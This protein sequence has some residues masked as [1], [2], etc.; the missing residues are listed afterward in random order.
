M[1]CWVKTSELHRFCSPVVCSMVKA[2]VQVQIHTNLVKF[3][4]YYQPLCCIIENDSLTLTLHIVDN[5]SLQAGMRF[6]SSSSLSLCFFVMTSPARG[7]EATKPASIWPGNWQRIS[8][9]ELAWEGGGFEVAGRT[10]LPKALKTFG[11]CFV[12][13]IHPAA[14]QTQGRCYKKAH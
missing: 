6:S 13:A 14:D 11:R 4:Y 5:N 3:K 10:D 9:G 2:S 1:S 12:S 8:S 7:A